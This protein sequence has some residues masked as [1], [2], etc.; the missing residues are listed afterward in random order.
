MFNKKHG[1]WFDTTFLYGLIIALIL[2]S[3]PIF[4]FD[5]SYTASASTIYTDNSRQTQTNKQDDL[6]V[7]MSTGFTLEEN[8]PGYTLRLAPNITYR[9]FTQDT[10]G[11][12]TRAALSSQAIWRITPSTFSWEIADNI[13]TQIVDSTQNNTP[14]NQQEI[15]EF[16]TGPTIILRIGQLDTFN[17]NSRYRNIHAETGDI[18]NERYSTHINWQHT[19]SSTMAYSL[20]YAHEKVDFDN[21]L[22]VDFYTNEVFLRIDFQRHL[23]TLVFDVGVNEIDRD[24]QEKRDGSLT[25]LNWNYQITP[26]AAFSTAWTNEFGDRGQVIQDTAI[27][28]GSTTTANVFERTRWSSSYIRTTTFTQFSTRVFL[29]EQDFEGTITD[30]KTKGV[31]LDMGFDVTHATNFG[32]FGNYTNTKF[33]DTASTRVDDQTRIGL[34]LRYQISL[35]LTLA[36]SLSRTQRDSTVATRDFDENRVIITLNYAS[37]NIRN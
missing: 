19:L 22:S 30:Q 27:Q 18:D 23:S 34:R 7:V 12:E 21:P 35:T 10:F 33:I 32:V 1:Q 36:G 28:G 14:D 37:V 6:I 3:R 15:N 24:N 17:I 11:D 13:S 4:A 26:R 16:I 25:R 20:N 8:Q 5:I 29:E 2:I 31:N 9:N